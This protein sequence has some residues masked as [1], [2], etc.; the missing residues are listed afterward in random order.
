MPTWSQI[1]DG[2]TSDFI[3]VTSGVR[4]GFILGLLFFTI[5]MN[6]IASLPLLRN[7]K[8]ILIADDV[9]L[10]KSI[11]SLEDK[12]VYQLQKDVDPILAYT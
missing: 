3:P 5:F 8:L 11:D 12:P 6:S 4:H 2:V 1:L 10:Y 7:S 9:L